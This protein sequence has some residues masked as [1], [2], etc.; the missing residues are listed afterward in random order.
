MP[1]KPSILKPENDLIVEQ[2]KKTK[3]IVETKDGYEI[4]TYSKSIHGS[5]F[6]ILAAEFAKKNG[7]KVRGVV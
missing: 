7:Y 2:T 4:R 1:K 6:D 5:N 3:M